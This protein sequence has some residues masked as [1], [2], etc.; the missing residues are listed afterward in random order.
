MSEKTA[1]PKKAAKAKTAKAET[2]V[3]GNLPATRATRVGGERARSVDSASAGAPARTGRGPSGGTG[4]G[5]GAVRGRGAA[6]F[7][8]GAVAAFGFVAVARGFARGFAVPRERSP[9]TRDARVAGRFPSTPAS[10]LPVFALAFFGFS[11]IGFQSTFHVSSLRG[12]PKES[13]KPHAGRGVE[14]MRG[15]L[16]R[17]NPASD[18]LDSRFSFERAAVGTDRVRRPKLL[19]NPF[20]PARFAASPR[21]RI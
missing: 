19:A 18:R 8:F 11:L 13:V 21:N 16:V 5:R 15:Y 17:G 1:K 3:L 9:P 4:V 12:K 10:S 20:K 2:G 14:E 7:G 6:G